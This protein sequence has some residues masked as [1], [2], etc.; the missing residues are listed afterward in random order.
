MATN[1]KVKWAKS[2]DSP[3]FLNGVE[4]RN[5]DFNGFICDD[6][7]ILFENLVTFC[8]VTPEFK[9]GKQRFTPSSFSSLATF[10]WRRH[11]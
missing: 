9:R 5:S 2:A 4:Y 10:A 7:A 6:L 11:C 8:P 3:S 1:F